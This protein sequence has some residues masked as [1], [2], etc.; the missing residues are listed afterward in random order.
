MGVRNTNIGITIG[1]SEDCNLPVLET[2][3]F[4]QNKISNFQ[5][6]AIAQ[7]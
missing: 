2:K 3:S 5:L 1:L 6:Y 4:I 7:Y